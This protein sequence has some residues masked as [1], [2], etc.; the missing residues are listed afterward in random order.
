LRHQL[1]VHVL[2]VDLLQAPI[3]HRD[4]L[5]ELLLFVS[6]SITAVR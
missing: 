1:D 6:V 3:E 4:R 2:H 5:V